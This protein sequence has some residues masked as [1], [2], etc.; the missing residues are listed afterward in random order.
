MAATQ[1][2]VSGAGV[3]LRQFGYRDNPTAFE[4]VGN[5]CR[6]SLPSVLF[7][8]VCGGVVHSDELQGMELGFLRFALRFVP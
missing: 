5:A 4:A 6:C 7:V 1:L 8:Y 2:M 3:K